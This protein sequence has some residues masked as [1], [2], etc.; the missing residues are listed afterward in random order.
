MGG[1]VTPQGDRKGSALDVPFQ[2]G[3]ELTASTRLA[4]VKVPK[5]GPES[6]EKHSGALERC[7]GP[8]HPTHS[9]LVDFSQ[10]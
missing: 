9:P 5:L 10:P 4:K 7:G 3:L 8:P 6:R 1:I 2:E